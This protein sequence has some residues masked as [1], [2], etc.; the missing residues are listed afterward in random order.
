[1][2][3]EA[4]RSYESGRRTSVANREL[5]ASALYKAARMLE[6]CRRDWDGPGRDERVG[7]AL[8]YNQRLW[9]FFQCEL[10][11]LDHELPVA[12]R[13]QLLRL[14]A[15][16][17]QRTFDLLRTPSAEGLRAL[18]QIN[19]L[20]AAGLSQPHPSPADPNDPQ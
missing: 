15:F 12:L 17:D 8:R 4:R 18:V 7:E 9:S 2:H 13:V 6:S 19:R 5:E 20:I 11:R 16:V 10:A 14:S 1:M 3:D